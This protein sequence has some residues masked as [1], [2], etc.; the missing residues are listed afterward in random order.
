M[1]I[2]LTRVT[3]DTAPADS[4]GDQGMG[5]GIANINLV[6]VAT[7]GVNGGVL[8]IVF[9]QV[10]RNMAF[11]LV[12]VGSWRPPLPGRARARAAR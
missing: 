10:S 5:G 4:S 8:T 3:G 1:I 2:K 11:G 9:S 6:P 7:G 12:M